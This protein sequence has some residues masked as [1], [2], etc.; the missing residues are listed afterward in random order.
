MPIAHEGVMT[1]GQPV[2]AALLYD[3]NSPLLGP[4]LWSD[5]LASADN[6]AA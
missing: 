5:V 2:A 6:F 4:L 1:E 3:A